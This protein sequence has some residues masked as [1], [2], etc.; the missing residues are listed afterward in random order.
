MLR[1]ILNTSSLELGAGSGLVGLA[2]AV[3]IEI[4]KPIYIS[5]QQCMVDLMHHN[6]ALNGLESCV[7]EL[8]IEW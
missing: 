6:I 3:G 1:L 4:D 2:V 5:D 8:V 7:R